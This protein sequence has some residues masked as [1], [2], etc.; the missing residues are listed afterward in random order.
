MSLEAE[1]EPEGLQ[2]RTAHLGLEMERGNEPRNVV[3]RLE[4]EKA[5]TLFSPGASRRNQPCPHLT[6]SQ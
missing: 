3:L 4:A 1:R 6:F 2:V 5:G